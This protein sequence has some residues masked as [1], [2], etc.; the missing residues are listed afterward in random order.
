MPTFEEIG[1]WPS[2]LMAVSAG[3]DLSEATARLVLEEVLAGEATDAQLGGLLIAMKSKGLVVDE[4]N[5]FI[6]A[7][8]SNAVLVNAPQGAID[9][10]GTGGAP[11]RR[12]QALSVSTMASFVTA[13][14]GGVVC[15]HGNVR[16]TSSSGAFDTLA[17]LGITTDIG[18]RGVEHCLKQTNLGFC[19]A[20]RHHPAMRFAGPVRVQLGVPTMFNLLGPL[21]NP[22]RVDHYLLGSPDPVMAR[23]L[24]EVLAT[25][26]LSRA[27]VV[28]GH[29]SLDELSTTGSTQVFDV[30]HGT[31]SEFSLDPREIGI[32]VAAPEDLH[33]G[34]PE[35]NAAIAE[36]VFSGEPGPQA[37][38][39]ALNAAAALYISGVASDIGA[40]LVLAQ[41]A[42]SSGA[43]SDL[44]SRQ[45]EVSAHAAELD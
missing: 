9:I 4:F 14:A 20:K 1:G 35:Q 36:R 25:R 45:R 24:G 5:G 22:A 15:K 2:V 26:G 38:I 40:G 18:A 21:V 27:W 19:F 42:M 17:A 32:A 7:M 43:V 37:D 11:S 33:G 31:L 28:S 3:E 44:L 30:S 41:E 34:S 29:G 16:A 23:R 13:A 6:A 39:V 12:E 8:L 10:V